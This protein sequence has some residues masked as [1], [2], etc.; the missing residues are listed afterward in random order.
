MQRRT[1]QME[2]ISAKDCGKKELSEFEVETANE[3]GTWWQRW[4]LKGNQGSW[5]PWYCIWTL[6]YSILLQ[7]FVYMVMETCFP[8]SFLCS[9]YPGYCQAH[10]KCSIKA[11][12]IN[13]IKEKRLSYDWR[14]SSYLKQEW[15]CILL[16]SLLLY[17]TSH[18]CLSNKQLFLQVKWERL[19]SKT[20]SLNNC[21][22]RKPVFQGNTFLFV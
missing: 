18:I 13:E 7:L 19:I 8:F 3:A 9:W 6:V 2:E 1:L 15:D 20:E 12:W 10:S 4:D 11:C 16:L 17:P 14:N 5:R 21:T 22:K